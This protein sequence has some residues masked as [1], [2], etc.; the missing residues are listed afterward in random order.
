MP[1]ANL[2]NY[3]VSFLEMVAT[4]KVREAYRSFVGNGFRHHNPF[5]KGDATSLMVAMEENAVKNPNKILE[6][7]HVVEEDNFVTVHSRIRQHQ[8]D[9]GASVVH[10]FRFHLN[11]VVE[12]WDI[13][14]AIP[15]D[16]VN[17]NGMF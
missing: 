8:T 4:G 6:V 7:L 17:E 9:N 14:M 1:G 13:G 11:Q 2:K 10:I 15:P 12:L 3:A 5:F 16:I